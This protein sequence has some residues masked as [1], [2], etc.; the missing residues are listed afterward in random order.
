[1][2][3][4][5]SF[6][7]SQTAQMRCVWSC[8]LGHSRECVWAAWT[9][10]RHAGHGPGDCSWGKVTYKDCRKHLGDLN[11]ENRSPRWHR[12]LTPGTPAGCCAGLSL[13]AAPTKTLSPASRL[14]PTMHR[15][16][17][18]QPIYTAQCYVVL[19]RHKLCPHWD[20]PLPWGA[21][22]WGSTASVAGASQ[23]L[24]CLTIRRFMHA[25]CD[26]W[27]RTAPLST[28]LMRHVP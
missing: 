2:V 6:G 5:C 16:P 19:Y 8:C 9:E 21:L 23:F 12:W 24:L 4:T 10:H 25:T 13:R 3:L 26:S 20:V 7:T 18:H 28:R 11:E 22:L 17:L 1:M 27:S 14:C 15:V